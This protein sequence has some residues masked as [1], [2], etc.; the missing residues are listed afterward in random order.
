MLKGD[1]PCHPVTVLVNRTVFG[2]ITR[3]W[4]ENTT[5][6]DDLDKVEL[7][8]LVEV[9][10]RE[11]EAVWDALAPQPGGTRVYHARPDDRRMPIVSLQMLEIELQHPNLAKQT[12]LL[13]WDVRF[14]YTT[15]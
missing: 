3:W 12:S 7:Y 14:N 1:I 15:S 2:D 4:N 6:H 11:V 10:T 8:E 5:R 13:A 9:V